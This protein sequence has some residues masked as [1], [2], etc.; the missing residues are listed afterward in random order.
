ML[1][2]W[3]SGT[4]LMLATSGEQP[5]VIPVSAAVRAGSRSLLLGLAQSRESLA[6]LRAAPNVALAIVAQGIAVTVHGHAQVLQNELV[7]GVTAVA[8][9]ALRIQNHDRPTF[10]IESGVSWRW[11]DAEAQQR[12]AAVRAALARL[13]GA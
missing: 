5:H 2:D 4:V 10:A 8:I 11:T 9:D 7:E 1:P 6:R 3:P 13:A 12:D